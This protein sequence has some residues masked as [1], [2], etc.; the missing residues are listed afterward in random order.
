MSSRLSLSL[1][2]R[3]VQRCRTHELTSRSTKGRATIVSRCDGR[4]SAR[5][6]LVVALVLRLFGRFRGLARGLSRWISTSTC[7]SL[8][9]MAIVV[10]LSCVASRF[11]RDARLSSLLGMKSFYNGRVSVLV[12]CWCVLWRRACCVDSNLIV[13]V[14]RDRRR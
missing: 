6:G 8:P 1:S 9:K 14:S 3:P 7:Y 10:S 4:M 11:V 12:R 5:L 13:I 2:G